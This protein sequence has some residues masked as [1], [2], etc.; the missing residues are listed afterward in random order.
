VKVR[1]DDGR[2]VSFALAA[3]GLS[4]VEKAGERA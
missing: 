3:S 4:R 2:E 1:Y